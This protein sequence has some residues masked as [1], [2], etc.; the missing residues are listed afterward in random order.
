MNWKALNVASGNL[1]GR[2]KL[3]LVTLLYVK[4]LSCPGVASRH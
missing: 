4:K 2:F 3:K 1:I